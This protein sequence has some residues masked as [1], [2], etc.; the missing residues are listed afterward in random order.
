MNPIAGVI[1][2]GPADLR[3][4]L[5]GIVAWISTILRHLSLTL[6]QGKIIFMAWASWTTQPT[7]PSPPP[8]LSTITIPTCNC[9]DGPKHVE[10]P[11]GRSNTDERLSASPQR[12]GLV[13]VE[14]IS[15]MLT[16]IVKKGSGEDAK[17]TAAALPWEAQLKASMT[18]TSTT[19]HY[20]GQ[21]IC[22]RDIF[23]SVPKSSQ[24]TGGWIVSGF[25]KWTATSTNIPIW[26]SVDLQD[27]PVV[28]GIS[29]SWQNLSSLAKMKSPH[30]ERHCKA[31][32]RVWCEAAIQN[33]ASF[34]F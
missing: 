16:E 17:K 25:F 13:T 28:F 29:L 6:P 19:R 21:E 33:V 20:L 11:L 1:S 5:E 15:M 26:L 7:L 24:E 32:N 18:T 3:Q 12:L 31:I 8:P 30:H 2:A 9:V 10:Y 4:R 23:W 27:Y 14:S 34:R 22:K